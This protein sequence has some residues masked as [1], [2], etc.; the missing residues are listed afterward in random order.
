MCF[1]SVLMFDSLV[2]CETKGSLKALKR[3][4]LNLLHPT[5]DGIPHENKHFPMIFLYVCLF[6]ERFSLCFMW[7]RLRW[8]KATSRTFMHPS[9]ERVLLYLNQ[10]L[11]T[12][13]G[14]F[15]SVS[16]PL[17]IKS[18]QIIARQPRWSRL[19]DFLTVNLF[20]EFFFE[21]CVF[22]HEYL[23]LYRNT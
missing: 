13:A 11:R 16:R 6:S 19:T 21:W 15:A 5:V 22:G 10:N 20:K 1:P 23:I 18:N 14:P 4:F 17:S 9:I 8:R 2:A 3:C 12:V 7:A